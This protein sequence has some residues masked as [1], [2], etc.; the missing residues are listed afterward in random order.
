[1]S[2]T[3]FS[4]QSHCQKAWSEGEGD[5]G[6]DSEERR[7]FAEIECLLKWRVGLVFKEEKWVRVVEGERKVEDEDDENEEGYREKKKR[8]AIFML[9]LS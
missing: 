7:D 9:S 1:M 3:T 6:P 2:E 4:S 8:V 5:G